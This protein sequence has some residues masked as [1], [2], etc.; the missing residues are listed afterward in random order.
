MTIID[1]PF[2]DLAAG[3]S[4]PRRLRL[5]AWLP[6]A[7][8]LT[9]GAIVLGLWW[10]TT[11][12]VRGPAGWL[13]EAGRISGLLAGYGCA[14]LLG[15]M[16]RVPALERGVGT[17][18]LARWHAMGGRYTVCLALTH[19]L[20]IVL[21]YAAAD[22]TDPIGEGAAI[23]LNYPEM[24]KGTVGFAL[25]V[26]VGVTSARAARRRLPYEVWHLIHLGSYLAIFLAFSHQLAL[27]AQFVQTPAARVFWYGMYGTVAALI[28]CFRFLLPVRQAFRH[29]LRVAGVRVEG[30]GVLSVYINGH[31]LDELGAEPGQFFRWRFVAPGL[32]WAA[33]PY[34]L[35]A[36]PRPG[37]LRITVKVAGNHSQ[38]LARLRPGVR[39]WA[40]GPYG[41]FTAARS[42]RGRSLLLAGGVGITPLRSLFETL[43]GD[44]VL[45]YVARR[46]G[47][48]AL[49]TE[50]DAIA[51][52]RRATVHYFVD[53]P[54][55]YRLELTG[56]SLRQVVP[57]L[58]E[59]DVFLCGPPGM[60]AAARTA[61]RAAH[62]PARR[63]HHESFE[64]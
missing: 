3:H 27:G 33:N 21:G 5:G 9:G 16:A 2:S 34:S 35:S 50:L 11:P 18:R 47:D 17:D 32:W 22:H 48:L 64:L 59:R 39:V 7:L 52:A 60:A 20:L 13:T 55:A 1:H 4:P 41:A 43:P 15:L 57:D 6:T 31:R 40:E 30:P 25:L 26:A 28:L 46:A 8:I 44:V 10:Q 62:V 58:A 36:A 61:L 49:R 19:V 54:A 53:E 38:A 14:V 51:A 23:V 45:I 63:I 42:R 37:Q 29:R 56:R 24:L 12:D